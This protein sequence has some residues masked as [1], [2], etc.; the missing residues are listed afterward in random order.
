MKQNHKENPTEVKLEMKTVGSQTKTSEKK[1]SPTEHKTCKRK[2][3][4]VEDKVEEMVNSVKEYVKSK[5]IHAQ[6]IQEICDTM[7]RSNL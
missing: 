7:Q 5:N 2:L 6:N 3:L 4:G 1:A